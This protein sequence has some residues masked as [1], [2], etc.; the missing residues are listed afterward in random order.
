MY[1]SISTKLS[2]N[3]TFFADTSPPAI[4]LRRHHT[5]PSTLLI[6]VLTSS[7]TNHSSCLLVLSD[8]RENRSPIIWC[9][10]VSV[11]TF[12]ESRDTRLMTFF[13]YYCIN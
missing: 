4:C 11:T 2:A 12:S 13:P 3:H 10:S 1:A 5:T 8:N 9:M 7:R 6:P